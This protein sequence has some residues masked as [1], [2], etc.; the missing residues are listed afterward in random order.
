MT[1]VIEPWGADYGM[2]PKD[3]FEIIEDEAADDFYFHIIFE[4]KNILVWVEGAGSDYPKVCQN[5]EE[6]QCGHNLR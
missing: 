5:G 1:L 4:E 6:L 3:K 2:M